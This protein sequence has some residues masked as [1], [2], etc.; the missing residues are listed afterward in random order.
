MD[1]ATPLAIST[2][3]RAGG[4]AVR[5]A[6]ASLENFSQVFAGPAVTDAEQATESTEDLLHQAAQRIQELAAAALSG[7]DLLAGLNLPSQIR[8]ENG[9]IAASPGLDEGLREQWNQDESLTEILEQVSQRQS[10]AVIE[11]PSSQA[12]LTNSLSP[13]NMSA[14]Y[15]GYPNW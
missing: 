14:G 7:P 15:G 11:I 13:A 10:E 3:V 12:R 6:R 9:R 1:I 8:V 5:T 4:A 2:V